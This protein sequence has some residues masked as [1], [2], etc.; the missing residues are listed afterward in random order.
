MSDDLS[1]A[2]AAMGRKGGAARTEKKAAA[3][4]EN[5][6]LGGWPRTILG[7]HSNGNLD[8]VDACPYCGVDVHTSSIDRV[9][10]DGRRWWTCPECGKT[11][12]VI[13]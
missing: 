6:K 12:R 11:A 2:A 8:V 5:G 10:R 4:R 1:R 9:D 7:N 3:V 13:C